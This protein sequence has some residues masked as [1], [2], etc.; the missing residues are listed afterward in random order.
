MHRGPPGPRGPRGIHGAPGTCDVKCQQRITANLANSKTLVSNVLTDDRFSKMVVDNMS[1]DTFT[2]ISNNLA[3][4]SEIANT[5]LPVL[6][7]DSSFLRN[8]VLDVTHDKAFSDRV[9]ETLQ[10]NVYSKSETDKEITR[11]TYSKAEL[12]AKMDR[13]ALSRHLSEWKVE[14]GTNEFGETINASKV[15]CYFAGE[16]KKEYNLADSNA[17]S[18]LYNLQV[19]KVPDNGK[20]YYHSCFET[21]VADTTVK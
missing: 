4:N 18:M 19:G 9:S 2:H 16:K 7:T 3:Q 14:D 11:R 12:D 15:A 5:V 20:S 17:A 10:K 8:V 6:S 1:T 21:T 13:K